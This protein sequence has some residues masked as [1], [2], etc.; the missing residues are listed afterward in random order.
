MR[1]FHN[2]I[3]L[4]RMCIRHVLNIH[5][6]LMLLLYGQ[7]T[8]LQ[9]FDDNILMWWPGVGWAFY[10]D[11]PWVSRTHNLEWPQ[12]FSDIFTSLNSLF[13]N[14]AGSSDV[15]V[16]DPNLHAS[17]FCAYNPH[18]CSN[19]V[20]CKR[21]ALAARLAGLWVW[22]DEDDVDLSAQCSISNCCRNGEACMSPCFFLSFD[23]SVGMAMRQGWKQVA[24]RL[25]K[26]KKTP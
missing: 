20:A 1:T 13:Y 25:G 21:V 23:N 10:S 5:A 4:H 7:A 12:L 14:N 6:S 17:F 11:V 22:Q 15:P 8:W 18:P 16:W 24:D 9:T 2:Q 3:V 26:T 19:A